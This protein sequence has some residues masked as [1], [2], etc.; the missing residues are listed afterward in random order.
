MVALDDLERRIDAKLEAM[1]QRTR[2]NVWWFAV[3]LAA[4]LGFAAVAELF[5][6]V[7]KR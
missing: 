4:G 3:G 5:A 2:P 1:E 6:L 7:A